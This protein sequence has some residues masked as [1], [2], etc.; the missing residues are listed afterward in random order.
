MDF[1]A[2]EVA[3]PACAA[4]VQWVVPVN[5]RHGCQA[6]RAAVSTADEQA[7]ADEARAP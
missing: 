6:T 4:R 7:G 3:A 5:I 2:P 1:S